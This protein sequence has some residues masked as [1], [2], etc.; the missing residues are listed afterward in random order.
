MLE[1]IYKEL[2][3]LLTFS[4]LQ[5]WDDDKQFV[6]LI[7]LHLQQTIEERYCCR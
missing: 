1:E 7:F 2:Q 6:S 4:V 3:L 5:I